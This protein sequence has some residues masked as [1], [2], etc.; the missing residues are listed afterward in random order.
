MN[1]QK[2]R[3]KEKKK[4]HGSQNYNKA[5]KNMAIIKLKTQFWKGYVVACYG[6][7]MGFICN[8]NS[9]EQQRCF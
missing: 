2:K 3:K 4:D 9:Q 5:W 6:H 1:I 8:K 7:T